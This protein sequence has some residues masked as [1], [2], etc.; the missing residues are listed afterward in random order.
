MIDLER[1]P[2]QS[3]YS[4]HSKI[5]INTNDFSRVSGYDECQFSTQLA[6]LAALTNNLK[7][8]KY[9]GNIGQPSKIVHVGHSYGSI[10]TQALITAYPTISDGVILKGS[11]YNV[12]GAGLFAEAVRFNIA[13]TVF[14][15]KYPGL[16][17][18]Y[19]A[20]AD[21]Y[22]NAAGFFHPGSFGKEI[23]W[24]TQEIC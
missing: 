11:G 5:S 18:G 15:R 19:L 17:S 4:L 20:F 6:I 7:Q 21:P 24:Y 16:D 14:P 3:Q 8:G 23:L 2:L 10:L 12:S 13:N 1:E 22:G 9:T